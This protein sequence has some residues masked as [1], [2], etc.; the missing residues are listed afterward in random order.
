MVTSNRDP[1]ELGGLFGDPLLASAAMD[2]LLH[3]A[4]V[5]IFDGD[6][7]R[8]P[9]PGRRGQGATRKKEAKQS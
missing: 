4:H 1:D 8:N 6:S 7:Y 9:P 2:R 3:D 5:L